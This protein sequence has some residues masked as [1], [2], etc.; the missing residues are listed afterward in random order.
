MRWEWTI[1]VFLLGTCPCVYYV[2]PLRRGRLHL[3]RDTAAEKEVDIAIYMTLK[4][5]NLEI[6]E[7]RNVQK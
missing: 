7:N 5:F 2:P 1:K 6:Q 3:A 4:Y